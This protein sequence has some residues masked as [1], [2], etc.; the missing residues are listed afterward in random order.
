MARIAFLAY[1]FEQNNIMN[2]ESNKKTFY[3]DF[4]KTL[5]KAGN[6]VLCI[7][8][9]WE[10]N[11]IISK[12]LKTKLSNF[13][14]D[15][16][17][18]ANYGFMDL[19][20]I[21][22]CPLWYMDI[23]SIENV[24]M[25]TT[26]RMRNNKSRC[27]FIVS[28]SEHIEIIKHKFDVSDDR[29][30]L[31]NLPYSKI[32][33]SSEKLYD[34]LYF[35]TNYCTD[36]YAFLYDLAQHKASDKDVEEARIVLK[37]YESNPSMTSKEIYDSHNF[38]AGSR[39]EI[40]DRR[41]YNQIVGLKNL[42]FLSEIND[43]NLT[44][45]GDGWNARSLNY[46]PDVFLR[47]VNSQQFE[48]NNLHETYDAAKITIYLNERFNYAGSYLRLIDALSSDA[49]VIAQK[50]GRYDEMLLSI[51]VPMFETASEAKALC[52]DLLN[53]SDK[54]KK[55]VE[56]THANIYERFNEK[57]VL[58]SIS[59][60]F[61]IIETNSVCGNMD[62]VHELA[63]EFAN[64]DSTSGISAN[65][66]SIKSAPV[67]KEGKFNKLVKAVLLR[68]G[69]DLDNKFNKKCYMLGPIILFENMQID[70]S[71]NHIYILSL[72]I[73]TLKKKKGRVYVRPLMLEKLVKLFLKP[74]RKLRNAIKRRNVD[75]K[76]QKEVGKLLAV[77]GQ[78]YADLNRKLTRGEKIK[79]CLFVSRI[80]CWT[81]GN[82]YKILLNSGKF[83]PI[84]VV[85]PFMHQGHDAMVEYMNTTYNALKAQ[86]YNVIKTYDETTDTFMDL[87][88]ELNPDILFYT[89]YWLPQF[90]ENFYIN[91][92]R[93]KL[94][95]Y[96]SY[97]Y[98]VAY[99]PEVMNFELNNAVDRYFMPTEIHQKMAQACMDNHGE[100]VHVVGAPKLDVFFDKTYK[101]IDNWKAVNDGKIRK[102][103]IWAPHHSDNFPACRLYVRASK[104]IRKRNSNRI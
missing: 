97:C 68:F 85:K 70:G 21:V 47:S 94:T 8:C 78:T 101:P 55:I 29:I 77:K 4:A 39:I 17:I 34:V 9:V 54:L 73:L 23:D 103:I 100:N 36:G 28:E 65:K 83:E 89:K 84:V 60:A 7:D 96:T 91:K 6:D 90:Q 19:A 82:L 48:L 93:D 43:I 37:Q 80:S 18:I 86:G 10:V 63:L 88:R 51:G 67:K 15:V 41:A 5:Q 87:R 72:P 32:S 50:G 2:V 98:D 30:L 25:A 1:D 95:F 12:S 27:Y 81:F 92:F 40:K 76:S 14:P 102:R 46:Y 104:E 13:N 22:D 52:D 53:N 79:I 20:E 74:L 24:S 56:T 45:K 57:N 69:Y 71:R 33:E 3:S 42:R 58:N 61:G 35:G 59:N 44:V 49:C 38:Y 31:I 16:C 75:A 99:H 26:Y 11:K 66:C 64:S 62:I